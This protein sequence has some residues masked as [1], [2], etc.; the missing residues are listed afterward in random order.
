MR[1][2]EDRD[3]AHAAQLEEERDRRK[4]ADSDVYDLCSGPSPQVA[5][6]SQTL[7]LR[8]DSIIEEK[9]GLAAR[10]EMAELDLQRVQVERTAIEGQ[11]QVLQALLNTSQSELAAGITHKETLTVELASLRRQYEDK[12]QQME[13]IHQEES[14][15]RQTVTSTA[16][17]QDEALREKHQ[18][19]EKVDRHQ[20]TEIDLLRRL[21]R[22]EDT[23]N[24]MRLVYRE[25]QQAR[26]SSELQSSKLGKQLQMLGDEVLG[27][28][29][30][31]SKENAARNL[32]SHQQ[33]IATQAA[34]LK[35]MRMVDDL[36]TKVEGLHLEASK[37]ASMP[38]H[39]PAAALE[40]SYVDGT[41]NIDVAEP[42][43]NP[44][45]QQPSSR[46]AATPIEEQ[47]SSKPL[48]NPVKQKPNLGPWR[49]RWR[50]EEA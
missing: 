24:S 35:T 2:L 7:Q 10:L 6:D 38:P 16:H 14:M 26:S 15:L 31:L 37:P 27:G 8:L 49:T 13:H 33:T 9:G 46:P 43:A 22:A 41:L 48:A 40:V 17:E 34:A 11:K 12:E 44:T 25:V 30:S 21:E 32:P 4:M 47:P 42:A 50:G 20:A 36:C 45:E 3:V 1:E 19:K 28:M 39:V 18:L 23:S 5:Q 29:T